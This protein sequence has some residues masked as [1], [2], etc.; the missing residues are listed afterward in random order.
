MEISLQGSFPLLMT[1]GKVLSVVAVFLVV[2]AIWSAWRR[3]AFPE[4][5]YGGVSLSQRRLRWVWV[6]VLMGAFGFGINEDPIA[7]STQSWDDAEAAAAAEASRTVT[8]TL[9]T[10]FYRYERE[11]IFGDGELV[12]DQL[13]EGFVLPWPLISALVAYLFLVLRWKPENRWAR[14]I[15]QGRKWREEAGS[16]RS[17]TRFP[18]ANPPA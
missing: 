14:R 16:N 12:G 4:L 5:S 10:P 3:E 9:P 11:R 13:L 7:L 18:A 1:V 6:L 15:L 8:T 2:A 17:P